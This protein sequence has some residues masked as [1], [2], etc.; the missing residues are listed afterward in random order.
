MIKKLFSV[1]IV[2][3]LAGGAAYLF[4]RK[5]EVEEVFN[6]I[7]YSIADIRNIR[8]S[9]SKLKAV[10]IIR[11]T[12]TAEKDLD[13]SAGV[14][15][16]DT[17]RVYEKGTSKLLAK[18]QLNI[19]R[20]EIPSKDYYDLPPLEIGIPLI[21]GAIIA[22]ATILDKKTDFMDRLRFEL[23]VKTLNYTKTIEF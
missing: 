16:L 2:A 21:N 3:A 1:S 15:T 5:K 23:D 22:I 4:L 7:K 19:D 20:L 13:V 11:A 6:K 18:S 10:V 17:V 8:V 12:N 9:E 14:F